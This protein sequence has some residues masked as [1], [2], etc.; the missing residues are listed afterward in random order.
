MHLL[1]YEQKNTKMYSDTND[2]ALTS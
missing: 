2:Q 1:T